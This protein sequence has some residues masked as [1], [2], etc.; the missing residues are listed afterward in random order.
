MGMMFLQACKL[1]LLAPFLLAPLV[2]AS[3]CVPIT[4]AQNHVGKVACVTGKV[5]K[6]TQLDSGVH[7]L[8]FC[9]DYRTCPFQVVIFRGDL[10]H[11]GDVRQ[12]QGRI[13][14]VHG[15]VKTY[16][17][18]PEIVLREARQLRGEAAH[19]PPLPKDYDVA[20]KGRFSAGKFSRP[21][22]QRHP[23]KRPQDKPIQTE[24]EETVSE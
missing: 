19:V 13:I 22:S 20:K 9:E 17:G 5:V 14:E 12:L 1:T 7:F 21:Q 16:D 8:N 6:V 24:D 10:K 4:E 18:R 15:E 11:V 23:A 2:F 3:E